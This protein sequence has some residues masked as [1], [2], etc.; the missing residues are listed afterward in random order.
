MTGRTFLGEMTEIKAKERERQR[1]KMNIMQ[2]I[3]N[4]KDV[5]RMWRR[6]MELR[7]I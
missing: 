6:T 2:P 7:Q 1:K 4:A 5:D 3:K